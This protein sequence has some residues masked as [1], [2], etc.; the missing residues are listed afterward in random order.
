MFAFTV[1]SRS[2]NE[3]DARE[4]STDTTHAT[5]ESEHDRV[6]NP[7]FAAAPDDR[8]HGFDSQKVQRL[9]YFE[10]RQGVLW[11]K[12]EHMAINDLIAREVQVE[13]GPEQDDLIN[14]RMDRTW[15]SNK[16]REYEYIWRRCS[17]RPKE[18]LAK[19]RRELAVQRIENGESLMFSSLMS[20]VNKMFAEKDA[21][22]M[23][24][25]HEYFDGERGTESFRSY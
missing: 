8:G 9:P 15:T 24:T 18:W 12:R 10:A 17:S 11:E 19:R 14:C 5:L 3:R 6:Y 21:F 16:C 13:C 1:F 20:N 22:S 25:D 23:F 2:L 4:A 7:Q